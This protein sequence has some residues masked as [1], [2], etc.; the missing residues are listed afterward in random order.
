MPSPR[1]DHICVC[2]CTY[3]R[4]QLL[5]RLLAALLQQQTEGLFEHS[6]VV[7]DNDREASARSTVEEFARSCAL[8]VSYGI[9]PQ[10]NIALARNRAI[11]AAT[12]DYVAL[13]DDDELPGPRWLL[14][15]VLAARRL[16][17][18][19]VLA[20]VLPR[21]EQP[22]P[23]WVLKGRFFDRP[24]LATG[25][26]LQW[27]QTRSGNALLRRAVFQRSPDWFDPAFGSGG[28]DRDFFRRKIAQGHV[29][30][31]TNDAAVHESVPPGRWDHRVLLKR[32]LL[33]GK[34]A[35]RAAD[36]IPLSVLKSALAVPAYGLAL[37]VAAL[38]GR[39]VLMQVLIRTCDHLGKL[40][41]FLH[42][43]PVRERYVQ[44]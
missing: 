18:D 34:M 43:T 15:L 41:A 10:Q 20:P 8:P 5:Q 38:L 9:E 36:N 12:G 23:A 21:Y 30:A 17:V 19:G 27:T 3:R 24:A 28:E 14:D 31:W 16:A 4:P 42:L 44:A 37:P 2:I 13:I 7:V 22:P 26:V 32:A 40:L 33:R 11:D 6:V 1:P 25:Q 29:F 35:L 39:H